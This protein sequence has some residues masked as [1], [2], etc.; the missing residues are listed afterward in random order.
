MIGMNAS[1][2]GPDT[3]GPCCKCGGEGHLVCNSWIGEEATFYVEC[4]DCDNEGPM[5]PNTSDAVHCWNRLEVK[6][7]G[8]T[9]D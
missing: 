4:E 9:D 2:V 7:N 5:A 1:G 8:D 3:A 6:T